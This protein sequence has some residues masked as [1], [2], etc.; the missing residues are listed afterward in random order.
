MTSAWQTLSSGL[1]PWLAEALDRFEQARRDERLGHA[2]LICGPAGSGKINLALVLAKRL[3]G[4]DAA[5]VTLDSGVAL[6]SLA[7]RHKPMDRHPDLHWLHPEEEKETISVEQVRDVIDA[8]SLTAHRGGAKVVIVEPAE[9]MTPPAAN[10]LLK[11][12]E[13]PTPDSYL[14]LL[15]HRPGK[16]LA[17][18]RSRCQQVT[19][20]VP[21]VAGLAAWLKVTPEA[22]ASA[23]ASIGAAPLAIADVLSAGTDNIFR[24]LQNDLIKL[25]EDRIDVQT[26][27]QAWVKERTDVAL[28]WLV[29]RL[30]DELRRRAGGSTEVTDPGATTLHNALRGLPTRALFDAFEKADQLLGLLGSG[31]NVELALQALLSAFAVNRGR[32]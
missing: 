14:L 30:H 23:R 17:T 5:P 25:C 9:A 13:E 24:E 32:S 3:L 26:V 12:L 11:T 18:I 1:C 15:S 21:E 27:A 29:R 8:L 4:S 22:V 31:I 2:W 7:A 20:G 19:I 28:G 10:A 16:L 6:A